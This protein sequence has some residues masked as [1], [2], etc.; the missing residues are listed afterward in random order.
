[1]MKK[2][3]TLI[4]ILFSALSSF[5]QMSFGMA[6]RGDATTGIEIEKVV[7]KSGAQ[8]AGMLQG[9]MLLSVNGKS[10]AGKN[11]I[12]A[13]A[14]LK[15]QPD[16]GNKLKFKRKGEER[17][18]IINKTL[19]GEM[20]V[21]AG[22]CIT[23]DCLNGKGKLQYKGNISY[24]YEG[25]FKNGK[26][27]GKGVMTYSPPYYTFESP[28]NA[29][30]NMQLLKFDGSFSDN[31]FGDG[32][33]YV[34]TK[35][36]DKKLA[37][38]LNQ[39]FQLDG[40]YLATTIASGK[41]EYL[42]FE[43]GKYVSKEEFSDG[44][45]K[46]A[47]TPAVKPNTANTKAFKKGSEV[48]WTVEQD[49]FFGFFKIVFT[50]VTADSICFNWSVAEISEPLQ[51]GSVKIGKNAIGN[52]TKFESEFLQDNDKKFTTL[53][54]GVIFFL[55]NTVAKQLMAKQNVDI[56]FIPEAS[57]TIKLLKANPLRLTPEEGNTFI[58]EYECED[59]YKK[60]FSFINNYNI[61]VVTSISI[62]TATFT[63]T[64]IKL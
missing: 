29:D 59:E 7:D 10:F 34:K 21:G 35:S 51:K 9:D 33:I 56:Q 18:V 5:A 6:L 38:R 50:A 2:T 45:K 1:M 27:D 54:N 43:N 32:N 61:P 15:A 30:M 46:P 20:P 48:T 63:L 25:D 31:V 24:V 17:E 41:K 44:S 64:K 55:S 11:Y 42:I 14:L 58:T 16:K 28:L 57:S 13:A 60:P 49:D 8:L 52:A 62:K 26:K 47:S 36:G 4:A 53:Q 3:I 37:G 39:N 23:G 22:N 12:E 19:M 40:K